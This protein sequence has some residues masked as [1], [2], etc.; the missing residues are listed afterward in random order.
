MSFMKRVFAP[1]AVALALVFVVFGA[2]G[3]A[4]AQTRGYVTNQD[5]DTVS[6]ID[7]ASTR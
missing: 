2:A 4:S 1:R 3:V 7:T 6:V 5:T